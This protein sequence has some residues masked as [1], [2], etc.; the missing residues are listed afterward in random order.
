MGFAEEKRKR[1]RRQEKEKW[2]VENEGGARGCQRTSRTRGST[3]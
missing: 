3:L 1:K 2:R